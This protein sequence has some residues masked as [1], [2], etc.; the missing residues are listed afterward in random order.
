[1]DL[2]PLEGVEGWSY[3]HSW[4]APVYASPSGLWWQRLNRR[5]GM[6]SWTSHHQSGAR[7]AHLAHRVHGYYTSSPLWTPQRGLV[8]VMGAVND[9]VTGGADPL[10]L[11]GYR[12]PLSSLLGMV[13]AGIDYRANGAAWTYPSGTWTAGTNACRVTQT[14]GAVAECAMHGASATVHLIGWPAGTPG[15]IARLRVD[16]QHVKDVP[17]GEA[18]P[19]GGLPLGFT[20]LGVRLT[21][22]EPGPHTVRVSNVGPA[23]SWLGVQNLTVDAAHPPTV[24]LCTEPYLA[25]DP[26]LW[27]LYAPAVH[28]TYR[29]AN[30]VAAD[31]LSGVTC[32]DLQP[33]WQ[34]AMY[35]PDGMHPNDAGHARIADMLGGIVAAQGYRDGQ[36]R[37]AA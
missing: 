11:A 25:P 10:A 27:P 2:A 5:A 6:H 36:N 13:R 1:M 16:G 21:G 28:D 9:M 15:G 37:M 30:A 23:G 22:L 26:A 3:A 35:H 20:H 8:V 14:V 32:V 4:S 17:T 18:G 31:G 24:L 34:P 33:G 12:A 7:M 19:A 29:D